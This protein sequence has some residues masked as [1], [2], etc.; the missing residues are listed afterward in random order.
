[1]EGGVWLQSICGSTCL[2]AT[3]LTVTPGESYIIYLASLNTFYPP[4]DV[5]VGTQTCF[6]WHYDG[7]PGSSH[8]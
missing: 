5:R 8:F 1:M 7:S 6:T 3:L 2:H 4:L